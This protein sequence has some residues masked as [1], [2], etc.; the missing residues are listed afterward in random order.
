MPSQKPRVGPP[1]GTTRTIRLDLQYEGTEYVGWQRQARRKSVQGSLERAL[2]K[3]ANEKVTLF[4]ASRTDAGVHAVQQVASFS[5]KKSRTPVEAFVRGANT[6]L[7]KDIRVD[8]AIEADLWFHAREDA[9]Q[10]TYRYFLETTH[11]PSV[12]FRRYVWHRRGSLDLDA[13]KSATKTILGTHDFSAFRTSGYT[14][15]TSVRTVLDA[16]WEES[17]LATYFEIT[18]DGFLKQMVRSLVGTLVEI[19]HGKRRP[20]DMKKILESGRRDRSG[21]NAPARG[22]FLWSVRY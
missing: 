11:G 22:L 9:K 21:V 6:L 12:F 18:A 5:L 8:S 10:K 15:K 3:I 19:G 16:K 17:P 20:E 1:K 4:G 13:M 14:T 7:P 2:S